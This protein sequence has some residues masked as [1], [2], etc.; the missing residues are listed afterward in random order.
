MNNNDLLREL[1]HAAAEGNVESVHLLVQDNAVDIINAS[2][3]IKSALHAAVHN[4]HINIVRLMLDSGAD[5]NVQN[6][7]GAT[8]LHFAIGDNCDIDII[9]LLLEKNANINAQNK[10]GSTPLHV[11]AWR[12]MNGIIMQILPNSVA[13]I[14]LQDD[15]GKTLL[16]F[17]AQNGSKDLVEFLYNRNANIHIKDKSWKAPIHSA[18]ENGFKDVVQFL[19]DL[20][21]YTY[22]NMINSQDNDGQTALHL[23]IL[24]HPKDLHVRYEEYLKKNGN[25]AILY[26]STELIKS[27]S[28]NNVN[29]SLKNKDGY[30]VL[31]LALAIEHDQHKIAEHLQEKRLLW[32]EEQIKIANNSL[33]IIAENKEQILK[34]KPDS[35]KI[36]ADKFLEKWRE[37]P[38]KITEQILDTLD[39]DDLGA[40]QQLNEERKV[41]L[42]EDS[43][44]EM[45]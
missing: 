10:N 6:M 2:Y 35:E 22:P 38:I 18:A 40:F 20:D 4:R 16:H 12:G 33:V 41:A 43:I 45:I 29:F 30:T 7:Y 3:G 9:Y 42:G 39:D 44:H 21:I 14:N 26:R 1:C 37:L 24:Y 25:V 31:D 8:P 19:L 36:D 32:R 5:P 27:L 15:D 23:A 11:A 28:S 13:N 34:L 17:A